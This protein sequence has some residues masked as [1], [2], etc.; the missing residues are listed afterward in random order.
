[1]AYI[2]K[3]KGSW[4]SI[5][6]VHGYPQMTKTFKTKIDAVR[7]SRDLEN[8]LFR[9]QHDIDKKKFPLLKDALL[10]YQQEIVP[11][12]RSAEMENKLIKYISAEGFVNYKLNL[13]DP[14]LIAQYRDRSL[15]SLKSS[16]VNRR[17][18]ILSH[19]FTIAKKEWGYDAVNLQPLN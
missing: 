15:R 4:Q 7:F 18:A 13:I 17:L 9:Q 6:R 14:K 1:M 5:V 8:K 12:K 2:R 10:R 19:L 3:R 11:L 16:S